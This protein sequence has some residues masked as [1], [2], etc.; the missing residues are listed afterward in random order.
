MAEYIRKLKAFPFISAVLV[1][2]NVGIYV[3]C[4][5]SGDFLVKRGCLRAV[6]VIVNEE[7][8]RIFWSM[9]LH[10]DSSHLFSNVTIRLFMGAMIEKEIGDICLAVI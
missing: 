10:A 4:Q 8:G 9:L 5:L 2:I 7:Y 6:E 1:A 3:F